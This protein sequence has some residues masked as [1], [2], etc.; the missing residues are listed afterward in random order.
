MFGLLTNKLPYIYKT[1]L[2]MTEMILLKLQWTLATKKI[3]SKYNF[4]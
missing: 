3:G 2:E 4:D 1:Q